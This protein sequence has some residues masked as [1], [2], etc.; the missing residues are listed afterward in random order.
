MYLSLN[1]FSQFLAGRFLFSRQP[2]R[3]HFIRSPLLIL[4]SRSLQAPLD[5]FLSFLSF[6]SLSNFPQLLL[7][8][9]LPLLLAAKCCMAFCAHHLLLLAMSLLSQSAT[10][11]VDDFF[12]VRFATSNAKEM[13]HYLQ[14]VF[15]FSECAH[16]GLETKSPCVASHVLRLG[17][18]VLEI[19][20]SL[21]CPSFFGGDAETLDF[22]GSLAAL[23]LDARLVL[24]DSTDVSRCLK[25]KAVISALEGFVQGAVAETTAADV[26]VDSVNAQHLADFTGVHG[27]G[28]CD[29]LF[30]VSDAQKLY[31]QAVI[32]GASAIAAPSVYTDKFGSVKLAVVGAPASDLRH[33][34]VQVLDYTG[35][36]LPH[37]C[38]DANAQATAPSSLEAVDHC[39]LNFSWNQMLP[40]AQFYASAFGFHE[41]WSVD[42]EDV[43]TGNTG[44][45]SI[46][47]TNKSGSV[48]IPINEPAKV[49]LK[50][51]IEEFYEFYGGPGVQHVAL[52]TSDI[53][54]DVQTFIS[55]GLQFNS[56]SDTYYRV[57]EERLR[58]SGISLK[59]DM[60][61]I[62]KLNILVDFDASTKRK[63]TDGSFSC[64]YILQIFTKPLHD[65]PTF[66]FEIIQRYDHDGF[67]K[68]TF[69]GLFE[70][71]ER[72]QRLRDTLN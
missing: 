7:L 41:F 38:G 62:K 68:G 60:L 61:Q 22:L 45:R 71:I 53:L 32:A 48:K 42:N 69:K 14:L 10:D 15:G 43:S 54:A 2:L 29:V 1:S 51:Q 59:E 67:G 3:V 12:A 37:Y 23:L 49:K 66:F 24:T 26:L 19:V 4:P 55:K 30:R 6:P 70:S 21:E 8:P 46:V 28:V 9:F 35:P 11:Y 31:D 27:M 64:N 56:I 20:S 16:R 33:T 58:Q 34:L 5:S 40:N 17:N 18:V 65:R 72:E 44:L 13:A 50:G 47:V 39:V 36:Y 25:S 57:L 52:R 63:N